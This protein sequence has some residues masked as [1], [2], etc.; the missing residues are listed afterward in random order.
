MATARFRGNPG[1]GLL[2]LSEGMEILKTSVRE[3]GVLPDDPEDLKRAGLP[4]ELAD[5]LNYAPIS[6]M[7][8]GTSSPE[9]LII[10]SCRTSYPSGKRYCALLSGRIVLLREK[11]VVLG[12]VFI[13]EG[14]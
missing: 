3:H 10:I 9:N 5:R 13:S 8:I 11:D 2:A 4:A 7:G 14:G 1:S 6:K 12:T